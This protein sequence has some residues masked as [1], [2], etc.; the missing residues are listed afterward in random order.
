MI[1]A[2]RTGRTEFRTFLTRQNGG[3][4][5]Y[6]NCIQQPDQL[7]HQVADDRDHRGFKLP[8][9]DNADYGWGPN[10][11]RPV[12]F[13]DGKPQGL[14]Q[15]KSRSTGVAN[16]AGRSA[17]AMAMAYRDLENRSEGSDLLPP[18]A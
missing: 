1:S 12:Y 16:I 15:F 10:S 4:T 2:A 7:F 8:D 9:Q 18:S 17:A 5:G 13:A 11:Y 14:S 6:L 3:S